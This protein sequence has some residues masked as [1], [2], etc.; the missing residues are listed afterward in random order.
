[1]PTAFKTMNPSHILQLAS[2]RCGKARVLRHAQVLS[3]FLAALNPALPASA[4]ATGTGLPQNGFQAAG[5]E[6]FYSAK[7]ATM[8]PWK[9]LDHGLSA[10][11]FLQARKTVAGAV[12]YLRDPKFAF[13]HGEDFKQTAAKIDE[14]TFKVMADLGLSG[15]NRECRD[16]LRAQAYNTW[17]KRNIPYGKGEGIPDQSESTSKLS[18]IRD[19][20]FAGKPPAGDCVFRSTVLREIARAGG[21]Q[22]YFAPAQV[23]WVEDLA[24]GMSRS[25]GHSYVYFKIGSSFVPSDLAHNSVPLRM[26]FDMAYSQE[27]IEVFM[28]THKS[29]PEIM[30]MFGDDP[31]ALGSDS[32]WHNIPRVGPVGRG[33]MKESYDAQ[34]HYFREE[35]PERQRSIPL[36]N[37]LQTLVKY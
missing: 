6:P 33:P 22:C 9:T 7:Y 26:G 25:G 8:T 1:M 13:V 3:L 18:E 30:L 19:W 23:T 12:Y 10:E 5:V 17:V 29:D 36:Y 27:E 21:L 37:W 24:K 34:L 32:R 15:A 20:W 11:R 31:R 16:F 35:M 2:Q 4:Q 28:A 14:I